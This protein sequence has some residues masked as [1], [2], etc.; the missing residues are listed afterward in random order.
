M[1]NK[2]TLR[3][4]LLGGIGVGKSTIA[5]IFQTLGVPI[6]HSDQIALKLMQG[7]KLIQQQLKEAF[8]DAVYLSNEENLPY[9][10]L[11][12]AYLRDCLFQDLQAQEKLASILYPHTLAHSSQ[13]FAKLS[14]PYAIKESALF[15]STKDTSIDKII[16]VDGERELSVQRVI[17]RNPQWSRALVCKVYDMQLEALKTVQADFCIVN[18]SQ[19]E[20][21][22]QIWQIHTNLMK[23]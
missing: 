23:I 22:P 11:N 20:L 19:A 2:R 6:F 14:A 4:L 12:R 5:R 16:M 13:W 3:I 7:N 21:L 8:G 9:L 15:A 1:I 10:Q 18:H 17:E